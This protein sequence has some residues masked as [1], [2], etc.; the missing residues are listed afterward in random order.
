MSPE[1][2]DFVLDSS[3]SSGDKLFETGDKLS[4]Y[5]DKLSLSGDS[6]CSP[7]LP[8]LFF[9][10]FFLKPFSVK[11]T[12][13]LYGENIKSMTFFTIP[14]KEDFAFRFVFK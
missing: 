1:L 2:L 3:I 9:S 5:G 13:L 8:E 7:E 10:I 11:S 6:L 14:I 4:K 12:Y